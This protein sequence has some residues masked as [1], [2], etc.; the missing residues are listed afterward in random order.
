MDF[1]PCLPLH[2]V[3]RF[4]AALFAGILT[5]LVPNAQA[6]LMVHDF[7]LPMPESQVRTTLLSLET[8]VGTTIETVFSV[9]LTGSGTVIHYD[10]WEDGYETDINNPV[11]VTT[12]IWGDGNNANGIPPGYTNDPSSFAAGSVLAL[13]NL[14]PLPRNPAS[15]LFDG[16]DRMAASKAIVVSR[17][18]WATTPGTVLAGAVEVTATIDFDTSYV[19]PVG[20]DVSAASMFEYVGLFVMAAENGTSV[21]IDIDGA[22]TNAAFNVVLNQGESTLVNGGIR[23]GATVNASKPV[24]AHLVTG[25]IG[26]GYETDWFTL[27]PRNQWYKSYY[28]PVGTAADGD[29]C[30]VF[31][32][33][34]HGTALTVSNYTRIGSGSFSVPAG[35]VF[36][37]QMP[38]NSGGRFLSADGRDFFALSMVGANPAANNVHDWGF[39]LLPEDGLTTEAVVGWGPG[40]SDLSVNGSPVWV[41][42]VFATRVYVDY[43]GDGLGALTD[44]NGRKYDV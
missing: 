27:Y 36:Q 42:P 20:Q 34:P 16:R 24:E 2:R 17:T 12:K 23:K 32:Y 18:A 28:T 30:F 6:L 29:A 39:T 15:I 33:N 3:R 13:R 38:Q 4:F 41:T 5:V 8:G 10:Q 26:A 21:T 19:S 40:S 22:G 11:Q 44:P 25:D 35:G 37:Y 31:V 43:N 9:V 14:V 7:Y 1:L